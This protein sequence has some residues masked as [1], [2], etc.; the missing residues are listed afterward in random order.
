MQTLEAI[1]CD[2]FA[3]QIE[4]LTDTIEHVTPSV[5]NEATRYLPASVSSMPG[6]IRFSVIPFMKEIVDCFD[7]DSPVREVNLRKGAQ[8]GYTT[9]L[10]SGLLYFMDH[11]R[12]LPIMFISL[13]KEMAT[14]RVENNILPMLAH[15][16]LSHIITS[17][18]I[19]NTRKSGKTEK[20]LQFEGGG[21]LMP[22]GAQNAN[23]MRAVSMCVI[24]KDEID[25]W[26]LTVG[27]DGD[28]DGLT[29][30]RAL[31]FW[32]RRKIFRGSTPTIRG[33]SKID[34]A[35]LKGDQRKYMVL[36]KACGFAQ[37]LRWETVDEDTG[38][39]GGMQWEMDGKTLIME[40]VCYCCCKCGEPHYEHDKA[41]LFSEEHGAHWQPTAEPVEPG[42]R[43]YHLP[44][45]Y[46]PIG[47]QPWSRCVSSYLECYDPE[48]RKVIDMNKYQ[49][50]YNTVLGMS[51]EIQGSKVRF[52]QV[53]AHRRTCYT[54]GHVP[55]EH[56]KKFGGSPVLVLTCTVDVHKSNLAVAV[57]GWT[58]DARNYLIDYWRFEV[59]GDEDDCSELTSPVWGRLRELLETKEYV[60]DD[61]RM[62]RLPLTFIDA[63][64]AHDTVLQFCA[65]YSS[66]V[67]P[68]L[69][70]DRA[71]KSQAILEFAEFKT[72]LG[73]TGYRIL[74]DHY[75]DRIAPALRREWMEDAGQQA[76]F[77]FNAPVDTPDRALQE[78]TVETRR[79]KVDERGGVTYYWHRPGNAR[80]E[81]WDLLCYGHAAIDV[82]AWGICIQ[83]FQLE[84]I[85]WDQFWIYLEEQELYY[86]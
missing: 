17:S 3:G 66:G 57:I 51:F 7:V 2:W 18:D 55:N 42:I 52:T 27:R 29:D 71:A 56:A 77:H 13:D 26:P 63:G 21:Y 4:G 36:C 10:E 28:P 12:T 69:G 8:V 37:E 86:S 30:V 15:S 82:L 78:L 1:G 32:E 62:Y 65:E 61:G 47:M 58:K 5:Y 60:A 72:Q 68:I 81:L 39:I 23:K 46:S 25:G 80:N 33:V 74:V 59:Q 31:G 9:A 48:T 43:S 83:H 85:D 70:R 16:G 19:G 45:L 34:A 75:K 35:Y 54:L 11:V 6:Y 50:F 41:R 24:M 79:E 14:E 38:I 84:T 22:F 64:Y 49:I 67:Y 44:G 20:H 73:T 40:S 53:S 76:A